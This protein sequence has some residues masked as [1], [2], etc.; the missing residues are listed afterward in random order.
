MVCSARGKWVAQGRSMMPSTMCTALSSPMIANRTARPATRP[1]TMP[2]MAP[3]G[4]VFAPS[5]VLVV[6]FAPG[7][8]QRGVPTQ[9][10]ISWHIK[11]HTQQHVGNSKDKRELSVHAHKWLPSEH[12]WAS[13]KHGAD[14]QGHGY[15]SRVEPAWRKLHSMTNCVCCWPD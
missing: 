13:Q 6:T 10:A 4:R 9:V 5:V 11:Q 12:Q 1:T 8:V 2:M 14:S 15:D 3:T 7:L